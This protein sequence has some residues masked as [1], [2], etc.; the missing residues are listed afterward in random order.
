MYRLSPLF[1]SMEEWKHMRSSAGTASAASPPVPAAAT[2]S[3]SSASVPGP[4]APAQRPFFAQAPWKGHNANVGT[5]HYLLLDF[6]LQQKLFDGWR[7]YKVVVASEDAYAPG[8]KLVYVDPAVPDSVLYPAA[9]ADQKQPQKVVL[10][11]GKYLERVF[12]R[13]PDSLPA[14]QVKELVLGPS[15]TLTAYGG[16]AGRVF[17]KLIFTTSLGRSLEVGKG[18]GKPFDG[19]V[20][21]GETLLLCFVSNSADASLLLL[22]RGRRVCDCGL[23]GSL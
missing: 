19:E 1:V 20:A 17:D 2:D 11:A 8:F 12:G 22:I 9:A 14:Q 5:N 15:E 21:K 18:G 10:P 13:E 16:R 6:E 3:K 23:Y 4:A 7:V